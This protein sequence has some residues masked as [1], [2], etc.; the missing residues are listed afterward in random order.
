MVLIA[1]QHSRAVPGGKSQAARNRPTRP[2]PHYSKSTIPTLTRACSTRERSSLESVRV[3]AGDYTSYVATSSRKRG[4]GIGV[5][6]LWGEV[7]FI[8]RTA[9]DEVGQELHDA[10]SAEIAVALKQE[11]EGNRRE[12]S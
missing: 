6:V 3:I 5:T 10:Q 11:T 8:P 12:P 1:K 4:P 2:R 9:A 7:V